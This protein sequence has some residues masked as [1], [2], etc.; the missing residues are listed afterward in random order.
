VDVG[1]AGHQ[2]GVPDKLGDKGEVEVLRVDG[3]HGD[4][5]PEADWN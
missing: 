3:V 2:R 5:Y 4:A 1:N